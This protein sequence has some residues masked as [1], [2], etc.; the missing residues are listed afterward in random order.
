MKKVNAELDRGGVNGE[1]LRAAREAFAE[2]NGVLDIR[3]AAGASDPAFAAW[4]EERLEAR[5]GAR[6]SRDFRLSDSIRDELLAKGVIIEDT[7]A[8]AKWKLK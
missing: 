8:G 7:P 5:K 2:M 4:V 1:G 3:P 6:A